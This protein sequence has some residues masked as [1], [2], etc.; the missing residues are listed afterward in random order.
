MRDP[1]AKNKLLHHPSASE[2]HNILQ[3]FGKFNMFAFKWKG[4]GSAEDYSKFSECR[5]KF[6]ELTDANLPS[7]TQ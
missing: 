6:K 3:T 7:K 2:A 4:S 1:Q 5:K